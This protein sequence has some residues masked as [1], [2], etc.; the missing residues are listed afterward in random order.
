[1]DAVSGRYDHLSVTVDPDALDYEVYAGGGLESV[2]RNLLENAAI[3]NDA[4]VA[5][6]IGAE[7]PDDDVVVVTVADD[8]RGVPESVRETLFQLGEAGPESDGVGLGLG[9]VRRLVETYGGTVTASERP[10][11]GA[12]FRIELERA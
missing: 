5:V 7:S 4:P 9:F 12:A 2:F 3:H 8:G 1:M 10:E 11:G 6:T